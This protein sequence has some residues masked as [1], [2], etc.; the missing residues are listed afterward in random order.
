MAQDDIFPGDIVII[1]QT[2]AGVMDPHSAG[3]FRSCVI[4]PGMYTVIAT[5]PKKVS[6]RMLDHKRVFCFI[7]PG[8]TWAW[9]YVHEKR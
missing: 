3:A 9:I 5:N 6:H 1:N 7:A 8:F 4:N 2:L